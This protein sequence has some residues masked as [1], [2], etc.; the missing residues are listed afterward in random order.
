MKF[1]IY[2]FMMVFGLA[3]I[4][5]G[6]KQILSDNITFILDVYSGVVDVS[7]DNGNSWKKAEVG[8][9]LKEN[10]QIKTG[11][12]SFCDIIM[13]D[14]GIFRIADNS[15]V[16]LSKLK[17]QLEEINITK[18]KILANIT[19]KLA[20]DETFLV[21]TTTAVVSVRGTEFSVRTDGDRTVTEV[22]KGEVKVRKNIALKSDTISETELEALTEIPVKQNE[23]LEVDSEGNKSLENE[24]N[25]KLEGVTDAEKVRSVVK[26]AA[27][28]SKKQVKKV[29]DPKALEKEFGDINKPEKMKKIEEES[30]RYRQEIEKDKKDLEQNVQNIKKKAGLKDIAGKKVGDEAT[31]AE[32]DIRSGESE[33]KAGEMREKLSDRKKK[34]NDTG[35]SPEDTRKTKLKNL[36]DRSKNRLRSN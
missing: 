13:P 2:I 12:D 4:S 36:M 24:L 5:C 31:T 11:P 17:K 3:L 25:K 16:L 33:K 21:E 9:V 6:P 32:Q 35:A 10:Y 29:K 23:N 15:V 20:E 22:K 7:T 26:E 30:E 14:R 34:T 28:E 8:L 1:H 18:G 27:D 19:K